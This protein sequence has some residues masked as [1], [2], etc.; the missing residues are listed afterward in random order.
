MYLVMARQF[1][2]QSGAQKEQLEQIVPSANEQ[3]LPMHLLQSP[4]QEQFIP[5]QQSTAISLD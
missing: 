2:R 5:E 1:C 4:D 3:P